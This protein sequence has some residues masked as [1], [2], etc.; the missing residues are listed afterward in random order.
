MWGGGIV[1]LAVM[2][3]IDGHRHGNALS[4]DG[5]SEPLEWLPELAGVGDNQNG[6]ISGLEG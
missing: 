6:H 1:G 3:A 2:P 4:G 5:S